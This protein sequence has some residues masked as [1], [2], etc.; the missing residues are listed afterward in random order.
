MQKSDDWNVA[1]ESSRSTDGWLV[2]I[3]QTQT[4][5]SHHEAHTNKHTN[6]RGGKTRGD[7]AQGRVRRTL[8]FCALADHPEGVNNQVRHN[9]NMDEG[10][11][12]KSDVT[13]E[14]SRICCQIHVCFPYHLTHQN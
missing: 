9:E 6:T 11:G 4:D 10:E 14:Q 13:G 1:S 7:G 5:P 12:D 3:P 8:L 2:S